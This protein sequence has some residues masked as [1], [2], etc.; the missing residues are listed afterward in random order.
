MSSGAAFWSTVA[1]GI[2]AT[3]VVGAVVWLMTLAEQRRD[4]QKLEILRADLS[5]EAGRRGWAESDPPG[6]LT[7]GT[8]GTVLPDTPSRLPSGDC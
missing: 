7:P 1:I 8:L 3:A 5:R 6:E 2:A 4:A